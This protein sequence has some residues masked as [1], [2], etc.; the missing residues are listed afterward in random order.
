MTTNPPQT[1]AAATG[2]PEEAGDYTPA[3]MEGAIGHALG[4]DTQLIEDQ[5]E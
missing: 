4:L 1:A 2:S 3:Q 5:S